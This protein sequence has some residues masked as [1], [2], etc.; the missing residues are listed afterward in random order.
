MTAVSNATQEFLGQLTMSVLLPAI[1]AA[2]ERDAA[3]PA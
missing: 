2:K 3:P 1:D